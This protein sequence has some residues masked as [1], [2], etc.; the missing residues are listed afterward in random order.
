MVRENG[1]SCIQSRGYYFLMPTAFAGGVREAIGVVFCLT[2][3][4]I[5]VGHG[6]FFVPG[7][8]GRALI[9]V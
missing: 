9:D 1:A 8:F 3:A 2:C 6:S 4:Y 5:G 7:K